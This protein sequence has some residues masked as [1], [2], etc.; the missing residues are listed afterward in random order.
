MRR[1]AA[2]L[3]L[4]FLLTAPVAGCLLG[5]GRAQAAAFASGYAVV[6]GIAALALWV[7]AEAVRWRRGR[8]RGSAGGWR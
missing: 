7:A 3:A 8:A 2:L 1:A 5:R 6:L 4:L